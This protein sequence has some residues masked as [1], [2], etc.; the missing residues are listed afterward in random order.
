MGVCLMTD[1][2]ATGFVQFRAISYLDRPVSLQAEAA[3]QCERSLSLVRLD[4]S[5]GEISVNKYGRKTGGCHLLS[6]FSVQKSAF[7]T[8]GALGQKI[9]S[10]ASSDPAPNEFT[11]RRRPGQDDARIDIRGVGFAP[12]NMRLIDQ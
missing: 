12:G 1:E 3:I 5:L 9:V 7:F 4:R 6:E 10:A 8:T 11:D 2:A